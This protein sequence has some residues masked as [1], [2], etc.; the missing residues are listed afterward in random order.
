MSTLFFST[1]SRL[2][3]ALRQGDLDACESEVASE[4][5]KLPRCPFDAVLDVSITNDPED[6]AQHFDRFFER[7]SKQFQIGAAYTEMN[8]FDINPDRWFCDLFAYAED[9]GDDE[10]DW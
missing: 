8:G 9:G 2:T 7:E 3:P 1:M 4:M 10:Y 6:A 5:Q